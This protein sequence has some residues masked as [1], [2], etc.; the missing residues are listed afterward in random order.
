MHDMTYKQADCTVLVGSNLDHLPS[1]ADCTFD[2]CVTDPPYELGFMGKAWDKSGIAYSV[3]LWREVFRVMKPGAH[4][5]AFGGS[6]TYHRMACAI[7]DAGFE[8]RDQIQ[9]IYGS[10]F[11]KS[12]DV[13]KAIDKCNGEMGRLLKFT[14]WMRTTG[15]TA[16][17][18]NEATGTFMGSHY[19]TDK[20]QPAIPTADLWAKLRPLCGEVPSWVDELVER[21]E[22][23]R[24]VVAERK[25]TDRRGDGTVVGLGHSGNADITAP[26]TD[27][28]KQWQGF[29]T[30][31]KPSHEP[32][33]MAR[34]PLEKGLT[35]AQNVLKWGTG[36]INVDGCRVATEEV[37]TNHSRGSESALSKGKYG[38][39]TAQDTHQTNG[40]SLGRFPANC[41][42]DGSDEVEAGFPVTTS[43]KVTSDKDAYGNGSM[44]LNGVSNQNNQHGDSGSASRF[45][46]SP[47]ASKY[48]R[49]AGLD[50]FGLKEKPTLNEYQNPSEG[51]TAPKNGSPARN[52]HP[53]VK[54]T[55]LMQYLCRL[56]TPPGGLVL[57]PFLGSGSTMKAALIERFRCVGIELNAEYAKIAEARLTQ[58]QVKLF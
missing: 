25:A 34:K 21:I 46:Y 37:I 58:L 11:P 39:S 35:V 57:D 19:L 9:W 27:E 56:V 33:C 17:Q 13:S 2:S 48:D 54:P 43:C 18:V 8:I 28:A 45:F 41:I 15:M 12:L 22:A 3:D 50:E 29:G 1:F 51:R 52:H 40:Q 32:I 42:H 14:R 36:A 16:K 30:A 20:T 53:T 4:L 55:D 49:E 7:E 47:K 44:F 31:L 6:R 26:A 24:E 38:D 23:E 5:L 10:G